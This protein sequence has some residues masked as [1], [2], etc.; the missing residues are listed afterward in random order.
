[1]P[2]RD[3]LQS[4][5]DLHLP[6]IS[7]IF[8]TAFCG[9]TYKDTGD[10]IQWAE[11][12]RRHNS[13]NGICLWRF[14]KNDGRIV[15]WDGIYIYVYIW[16]VV[17]FMFQTTHQIFMRNKM[18][19][20]EHLTAQLGASLSNFDWVALALCSSQDRGVQHRA[21]PVLFRLKSGVYPRAGTTFNIF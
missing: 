7:R 13:I 3:H 12:L 9:K 16:K 4:Q 14:L 8:R 10:K 5:F 20:K 19:K 2:Q 15:T 21:P 11:V 1:M 6:P 17:K 18:S